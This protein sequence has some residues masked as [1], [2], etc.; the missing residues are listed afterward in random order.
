M[1]AVLCACGGFGVPARLN[2]YIGW[3]LVPCQ[4]RNAT[5]EI[6]QCTYLLLKELSLT[7]YVAL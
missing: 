2:R 6:T 5:L 7:L 4:V 3:T 1:T